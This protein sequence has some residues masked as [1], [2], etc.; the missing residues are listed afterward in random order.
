[1]VKVEIYKIM[2]LKVVNI[3]KNISCIN[4]VSIK[5]VDSRLSVVLEGNKSCNF[6]MIIFRLNNM[7][8][9]FLK[10]S[11]IVFILNTYK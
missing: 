10:D 6:Y 1:M 7:S 9:I 11:L 8:F 4:R 5:R 3:I 2:A